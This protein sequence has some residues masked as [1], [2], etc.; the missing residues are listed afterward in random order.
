MELNQL[1]FFT[2]PT[3]VF[4]Q[5]KKKKL[6]LRNRELSLTEIK[7]KKRYRAGYGVFVHGALC[8]CY[9]GQCLR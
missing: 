4:Y 1:H 5:K 8:Y 9:S 3:P 2:A 7:D 6:P